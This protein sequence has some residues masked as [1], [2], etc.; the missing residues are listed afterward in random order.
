MH[1][2]RLMS[3]VEAVANVAVGLIVALAAQIVVFPVLG[4]R[5]ASRS[6]A[7]TRCGGCSRDG[8]DPRGGSRC[9]VE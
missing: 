7:A 9:R 6:R 3:L 4:L 5:E 2:S 8:D 1:Q